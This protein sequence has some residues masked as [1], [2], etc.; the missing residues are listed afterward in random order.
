MAMETQM[1]DLFFNEQGVRALAANIRRAWPAFREQAFVQAIV[2]RFPKLG[3]N[4]RNFLVR[5]TLRRDLPPDYH[6]ALGILLRSLGPE[7]PPEGPGSYPGFITMS[8]C[9]FVAAYGLGEVDRSL[10]ALREMTKRFSAEFAIRPFLERHPQRTLAALRAWASD[11]DPRVRRLVSEGTRPRLPWGMRLQRFIKDPRP[12]LSLLEL[13][14]ED[15]EL[16]VRRSV[17][18]NLNDIAKDHADLVVTMLRRWGKSRN[19]ETKW[20][21]KHALRTLLKQGHAEA[22]ELLGYPRKAKVTV[23]NLRVAPKRIRAGG[24]VILAFDVRS[25]GSKPQPLMIDYI[26]HHVKANGATR[27]KVFKLTTKTIVPRGRLRIEKKHS[28]RPIGIRPYYPGRHAIEV[29]INGHVL[30]RAT[31]DLTR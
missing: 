27:P 30:A 15:P 13:L 5:D 10:R 18:N 31:F 17:A 7:R 14:K 26:V 9:A 20:V 29:Q 16:F 28:F 3:L 8:L 23:E 21:V 2:S 19:P 24:A 4:E 22:L 6:E 25:I 1:R 12:V 11:D